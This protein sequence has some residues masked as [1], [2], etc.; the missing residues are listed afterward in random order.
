MATTGIVR[1]AIQDRIKIEDCGG[2]YGSFLDACYSCYTSF[3]NSNPTFEGKSLQRNRNNLRDGKEID[4]WGIVDVHDSDAQYPSMERYEKVSLLKYLIENAENS[5]D[6]FFIKRLHQRKVRIEIFSR[7]ELYSMVLQEIGSTC[8]KI[9]F[10]TAH[11]ISER[12]L[13]KKEKQ[14]LEYTRGRKKPL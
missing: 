12:Q 5:R 2:N 13:Q 6:V 11:P 8:K 9:Q 4:F 3:W 10:I 1:I 14:L 7:S